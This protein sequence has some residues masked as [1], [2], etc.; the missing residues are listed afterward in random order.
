MIYTGYVDF[1]F[2]EVP[3]IERVAKFAE[4]GIR[5]LDVWAWR[6]TGSKRL[7]RCRQGVEM[8]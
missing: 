8:R 6:S 5:D 2:R 1:W 3:L 7:S 4:L